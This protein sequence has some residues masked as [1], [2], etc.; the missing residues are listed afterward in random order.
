MIAFEGIRK[1]YD[2]AVAVDG[3]TL[4]VPART[5]VALLGPSGCGKS[6]LLRM[7]VGLVQPDA[8]SVAIAGEPMTPRTAQ[9]LR[10]RLGYVIQAGGLFPHLSAKENVGLM[11]SHLGWAAEKVDGRVAEL[12]DLVRLTGAL[13]GRFPT[14]LSGG[15]AQRVGLMRALMLDPEVLLL[16][17]PMGALDPMV[18]RALQED[19]RAIF[20]KLEKTVLL[21]THDLGEA[22]FLSDDV[23]LMNAGAVVQ[24]GSMN[25]LAEAPASGFVTEFLRAQSG[26][27]SN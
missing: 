22:A 15:Q 14:E 6:T 17:E 18:R 21:V 23:V 16:D 12:S 5:T 8:G 27:R 26:T 2:G 3:V 11:A 7:A 25:A 9:A 13:L 20:A 10:L 1:V 19:L 24:R 4:V